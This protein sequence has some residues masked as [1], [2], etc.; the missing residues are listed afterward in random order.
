MGEKR[1]NRIG[2]QGRGLAEPDG[3][4][5]PFPNREVPGSQQQTQLGTAV[6]VNFDRGIMQVGLDSFRGDA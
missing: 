3:L 5:L 6:Q 2:G 1:A 4:S